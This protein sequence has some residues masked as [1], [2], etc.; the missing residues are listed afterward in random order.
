M[1]LPRIPVQYHMHTEQRVIKKRMTLVSLNVLIVFVLRPLPTWVAYMFI[2]Y[3]TWLARFLDLVLIILT[4]RIR[5]PTMADSSHFDKIDKDIRACEQQIRD[6]EKE[7]LRLKSHR[8]AI[9]P[10]S[11]LPPDILSAIF[12]FFRGI[13]HGRDRPWRWVRVT[14][15][16]HAWREFAF[17]DSRLWTVLDMVNPRWCRIAANISEPRL[18][19]INFKSHSGNIPDFF[20]A[21]D[22]IFAHLSRFRTLTMKSLRT[23]HS[24]EIFPRFHNGCPSLVSLQIKDIRQEIPSKLF[25]TVGPH[26]QSLKLADCSLNWKSLSSTT[27]LTKL[28]MCALSPAPELPEIISI[29]QSNMNQLQELKLNEFRILDY[30]E[31]DIVQRVTLP[32]LERLRIKPR[33]PS[34]SLRSLLRL[35]SMLDIPEN[36]HVRFLYVRPSSQDLGELVNALISMRRPFPATYFKIKADHPLIKVEC[37]SSALGKEGEVTTLLS[38]LF[39]YAEMCIPVNVC[40]LWSNSVWLNEFT[41][42]ASPETLCSSSIFASLAACPNLHTLTLSHTTAHRF[43]QYLLEKQDQIGSAFEFPMLRILLIHDLDMGKVDIKE[44]YSIL[45]CRRKNKFGLDKLSLNR[46]KNLPAGAPEKLALLVGEFVCM[47]DRV[48]GRSLIYPVDKWVP[49]DT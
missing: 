41:V 42:E 21:I 6:I 32:R 3:T 5:P 22:D 44:I 14:A 34:P 35:L 30:N 45:E 4:E 39:K 20:S 49:D 19:S 46:C 1:L 18:L 37:G 40:S 48:L 16:C 2:T 17:Q 10:I 29:L 27:A 9:A 38:L 7:I 15:V 43:F 8:N 23:S 31:P 47:N 11:T 28:D 25:E 13:Y 26:L 36:A 24:E 33:S 12:L